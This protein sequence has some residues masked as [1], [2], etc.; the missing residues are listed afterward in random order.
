MA[1]APFKKENTGH[2][3]VQAEPSCWFHEIS[4]FKIVHHHFHLGKYTPS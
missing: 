2:S 1:L 3:W 4:L